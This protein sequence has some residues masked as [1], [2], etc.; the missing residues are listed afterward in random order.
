MTR[1]ATVSDVPGPVPVR[2]L[3]IALAELTRQDLND[4]LTTGVTLLS[5]DLVAAAPHRVAVDIQLPDQPSPEDRGRHESLVELARG[6][7]QGYVAESGSTVE[8][9]NVVVSTESQEADR[10]TTWRF[11]GHPDGG[12]ARGATFDLRSNR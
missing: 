9:V 8:P 7:V 6:L 3:T 2:L 12:L 10:S 5:Q 4:L 11:L 1:I